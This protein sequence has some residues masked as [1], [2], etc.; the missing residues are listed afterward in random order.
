M[1][2]PAHEQPTPS[3]LALLKI[4]WDRGKPCSVREVMDS[5][6]AEANEPRAY[7]TVMSL[8]TVMADK[9][10][11]TRTP[12]GRAFL[13]EPARPRERTLKALVGETLDRAFNGSAS[14]LVAHLLDQSKPTIDELSQI[15]ALLDEYE[16]RSAP[17][18][19]QG[20][21]PSRSKRSPR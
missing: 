21:R 17:E 14:L 12:L 2:R 9:G 7:T 10:L 5:L 3:E 8:L 11:L 19:G 4:L 15:R 1:A 13:Y 18:G 20:C 16:Q 6:N